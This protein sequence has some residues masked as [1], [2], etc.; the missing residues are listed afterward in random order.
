MKIR[1]STMQLL[2]L[3]MYIFF[4]TYAFFYIYYTGQTFGDYFKP[5]T[6]E[7]YLLLAYFYVI[8]PFI[9][10]G[11]YLYP[12]FHYH[13]SRIANSNNNLLNQSLQ[14]KMTL[15]VLFLQTIFIIFNLTEG[16]NAAGSEV[17]SDSIFKYFF[18]FF[19]PDM[20]FLILYGF[21]RDNNFFKYNTIIYFLSN[22]QRGWMMGIFMLA[23]MELFVYFKKHGLSKKMLVILLSVIGAFIVILPYIVML[24]WAARA[25]F[26]GLSNDFNH[27]LEFIINL[28]NLTYV[29]S[30]GESLS[31]LFGRFQILSN[32]YLTLE[33]IDALQE[34]RDKGL[35]VS[36]FFAG[37]P[38][39]LFYKLFSIDYTLFTSYLVTVMDSSVSLE[40]L[41]SNTHGGWIGWLLVEPYFA[42][43]FILYNSAL[44]Y[45][46]AFFSHKI[47]GKYIHEVS[48]VLM[49]I[50]LLQGWLQAYVGYLVALIIFYFTKR[51]ISH[52]NFTYRTL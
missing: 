47:G 44:V 3:G 46:V 12:Y 19:S 13:F 42:F 45:L 36:S 2:F 22:I 23:I 26:G 16:V 48:W 52:L 21:A 25:Y 34:A 17:K 39:M 37:L 15:F 35:F 4:N 28:G 9:F 32:V 8:A 14:T 10:F 30:L 5:A 33:H 18:I 51:I 20:F 40:D 1:L 24:K 29:E 7:F 50:F 38:Q 11:W 49:V 41:H 43:F 31:Y 27:E 6:N